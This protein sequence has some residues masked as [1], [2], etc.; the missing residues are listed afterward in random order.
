V[1]DRVCAEPADEGAHKDIVL[2]GR[3]AHS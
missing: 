2:I 3:L 1:H